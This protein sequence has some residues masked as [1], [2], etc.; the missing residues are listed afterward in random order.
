M[1]PV[2]TPDEMRRID[3]AAPEPVEVLIDR[4]GFALSRTA[5]AMLGSGYGR[6]VLVLAGKGNNGADGRSAARHLA[7]R[8]VVSEVVDVF[9]RPD[10]PA[11]RRGDGFDLIIDAAVGTGLGRPFNVFDRFDPAGVPVLAVDIP[12]GIDGLT[13][14]INGRVLPAAVTVTFAAAKP[15]LLLMPGRAWCGRIEVADIGLDCGRPAMSWV[16]SGDVGDCWPRRRA[17]DHKWHHALAVVGGGPGMTGA[18]ALVAAGAYRAGAGL[19]AIA[20]PGLR[21]GRRVEA[22]LGPIEAIDL[23]AD[24]VWGAGLRLDR[25]AAAVVGPGLAVGDANRRAIAEHLRRAQVVTVFD[26]GALH[27]I[28]HLFPLPTAEDRPHILTPHDGE[29]QA[30]FGRAPGPDRVGAARYGAYQ[31]QA[32]LLMKGPTTIVA[33]PDGRVALCTSGDQRLATAGSGDV[34][35]GI[36][37]AGLAGGLD[38]FSAAALG[39]ELHALAARRGPERGLMASDIAAA[40]PDVLA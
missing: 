14:A 35:S 22:E 20:V 31:A 29:F 4:A 21:R 9:D 30:L 24:D 36:I 5:L 17:D 1:R 8:G 27:Q 39:A 19:V 13:G 15:G 33:H 12:S 40:I 25:Y 3:L 34:L 10:L 2:V 7:R 38:S 26:A 32:V 18:P 23:D 28:G 6:R 16:G 37:G 11:V